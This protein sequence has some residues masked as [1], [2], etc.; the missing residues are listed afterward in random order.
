MIKIITKVITLFSLLFTGHSVL[1]D[2]VTSEEVQQAQLE[3][4]NRVAIKANQYARKIQINTEF[5]EYCQNE[6]HLRSYNHPANGQVPFGINYNEIKTSKHLKSVLSAR[7]SDESSFL[8][9]CLAKAKNTLTE[10][11]EQ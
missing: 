9:L 2:P 4:I 8:I 5:V 11:E 1:A 7:E 3:M 6:M 10:A